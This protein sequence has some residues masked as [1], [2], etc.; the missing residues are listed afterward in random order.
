M[1]LLDKAI[2]YQR[3]GDLLE[4][5]SCHLVTHAAAYAGSNTAPC[6]AQAFGIVFSLYWVAGHGQVAYNLSG[7][8]FAPCAGHL[9]LS[10]GWLLACPAVL[11]QICATSMTL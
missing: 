1:P 4:V 5:I 3:I 6:A 10:H 11:F 2:L 8:Q 9:P 7:F